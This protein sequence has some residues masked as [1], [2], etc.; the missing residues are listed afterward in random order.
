MLSFDSAKIQKIS[1]ISSFFF[2]KFC[3][4]GKKVLPLQAISEDGGV[5][6]LVRASDS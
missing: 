4:Y 2:E 3:E 6:Q 5:A 1:I